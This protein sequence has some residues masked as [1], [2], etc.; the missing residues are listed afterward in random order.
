MTNETKTVLKGDVKRAWSRPQL[1]R[2]EAGSAESQRAT[3]ADGGG[4]AQAS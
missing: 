2:L 1:T 4:G 3:V